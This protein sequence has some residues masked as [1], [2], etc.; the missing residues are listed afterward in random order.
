MF[1]RWHRYRYK[2]ITYLSL[3]LVLAILLISN[4]RFHELLLH[5]GSLGYLGALLGG[6]LFVST[7]TVASGTVILMILAESLPPVYVGL[8]AGLGA[9]VGDLLIFR[10]IRNKGLASEIEHFFEYFGGDKISH[11]VHS[12]YFSWT[13]PVIGALIIASP[14]PD[15]LGVGLMGISKMKTRN[16]VIFS[17]ILN[18]LG[19]ILVISAALVFKP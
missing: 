3:S 5:I 4:D 13:L 1:D 8:I 6:A 12:K 19:I 10:S 15:E 7:F 16:F 18:S 9:V 17:F 14:L 2:N 11:L